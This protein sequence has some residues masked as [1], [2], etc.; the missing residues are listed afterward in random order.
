VGKP[1]PAASSWVGTWGG[2][3][4]TKKIK[5]KKKEKRKRKRKRKRKKRK[6]KERR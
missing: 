6:G 1:R 2:I 3:R 4:G 5:K